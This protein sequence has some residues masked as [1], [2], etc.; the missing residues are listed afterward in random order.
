MALVFM[1]NPLT[2]KRSDDSFQ[3]VMLTTGYLKKAKFKVKGIPVGNEFEDRDLKCDVVLEIDGDYQFTLTL[4][5]IVYFGELTNGMISTI[6]GAFA[7]IA[8]AL[9]EDICEILLD[10]AVFGIA[11]RQQIAVCVREDNMRI[12]LL[13]D[14]AVSTLG[15]V[16]HHAVL[17]P[18]GF[19]Q[20]DIRCSAELLADRI[21]PLHQVRV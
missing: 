5:M 1:L 11:E 7:L 8:L 6:C 4:P 16:E 10:T 2:L 15:E 19:H 21:H 13:H 20:P 3:V 18:G 12:I 9:T 14:A 17:L